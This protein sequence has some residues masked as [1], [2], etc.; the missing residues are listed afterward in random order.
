MRNQHRPE[1][2]AGQW[3][4]PGVRL[5]E[6]DDH[7][8]DVKDERDSLRS[9]VATLEEALRLMDP[10]NAAE[11]YD[12]IAEDFYKATGLMA[13]GKSTPLAM[14]YSNADH[15]RSQ[16]EWRP[17]VDSWNEKFFDAALAQTKKDGET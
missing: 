14:Q 3:L 9:R 8:Q 2:L 13:P 16:R 11:R 15:E 6:I 12:R 5:A 10:R 7:L 17:F 4:I 1:F